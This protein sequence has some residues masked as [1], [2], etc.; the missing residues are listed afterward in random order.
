MKCLPPSPSCPRYGELG[1][2]DDGS[3]LDYFTLLTAHAIRGLLLLGS[4]HPTEILSEEDT[5]ASALSR[6]K[7]K[8]AGGGSRG[9]SGD[10]GLLRRLLCCAAAPRENPGGEDEDEDSGVI[11]GKDHGAALTDAEVDTV[12]ERVSQ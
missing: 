9:G 7:N 12:R 3:S 10:G 1:D 11:S 5:A 4:P 2:E 6:K 8:G